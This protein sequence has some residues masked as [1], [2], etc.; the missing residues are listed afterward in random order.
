VSCGARDVAIRRSP[1]RVI[2]LIGHTLSAGRTLTGSNSGARCVRTPAGLVLNRAARYPG[3]SR[4]IRSLG[5]VSLRCEARILFV[6]SGVV[7]IFFC[8]AHL[9]ASAGFHVRAPGPVSG[10]LSATARRVNPYCRVIQRLFGFAGGEASTDLELHA[11]LTISSISNP[12][13]LS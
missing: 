1:N 9:T 6:G 11:Q 7:V 5:S 4:W 12:V 3:C 8:W 2:G 10:R 13:V